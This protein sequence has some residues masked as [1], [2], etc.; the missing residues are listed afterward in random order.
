MDVGDLFVSRQLF[1]PFLSRLTGCI[2]ECLRC[3]RPSTP[4]PPAA[5]AVAPAPFT[6]FI[7]YEFK[8]S[9]LPETFRCLRRRPLGRYPPRRQRQGLHPSRRSHDSRSRLVALRRVFAPALLP[10]PPELRPPTGR[11]RQ[12][13]YPSRSR[14]SIRDLN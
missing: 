8:T 9:C 7:T 4:P 5:L 10:R 14:R 11:R 6:S 13:L 1:F 2:P 3:P 12:C